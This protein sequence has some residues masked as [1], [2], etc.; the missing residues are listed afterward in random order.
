MSYDLPFLE[1][2]K[3]IVEFAHNQYLVNI[4]NQKLIILKTEQQINGPEHAYSI[5]LSNEIL[6]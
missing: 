5:Y 2:K 4:I 3:K 6:R 1:A